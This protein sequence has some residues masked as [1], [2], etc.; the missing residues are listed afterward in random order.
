[1]Q[2]KKKKNLRKSAKFTSEKESRFHSAGLCLWLNMEII[3]TR[4]TE[5]FQSCSPSKQ[6]FRTITMNIIKITT[7]I[8]FA[9][10]AGEMVTKIREAD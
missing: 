7:E 5:L 4:K 8:L 1:M 9:E 2:K 3:T 6:I 10:N